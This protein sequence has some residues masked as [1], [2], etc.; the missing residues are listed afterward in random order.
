MKKKDFLTSIAVLAAA[1]AFEASAALLKSLD[2]QPSVNIS[3]V[4]A[5]PKISTAQMPFVL[6]HPAASSAAGAKHSYHSSH[7]SHA[8]HQSHYSSRY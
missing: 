2:E 5:S 7:S 6:E 4:V 8:S 1:M 3:S